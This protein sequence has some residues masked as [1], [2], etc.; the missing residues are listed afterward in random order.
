MRYVTGIVEA[1]FDRANG[2]GGGLGSAYGRLNSS[3]L[4][5]GRVSAFGCVR[6]FIVFDC[7]EDVFGVAF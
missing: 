1:G 3:Y 6:L 4:L 7:W 2:Y 5:F